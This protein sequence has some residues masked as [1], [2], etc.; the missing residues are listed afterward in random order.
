M[1]DMWQLMMTLTVTLNLVE[2]LAFLCCTWKILDS[3]HCIEAS[4]AN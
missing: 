4:Y 3:F 1:Y 2:L